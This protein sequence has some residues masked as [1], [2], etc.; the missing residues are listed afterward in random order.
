MGV[1]ESFGIPGFLIVHNDIHRMDVKPWK[2]RYPDIKVIA[3]A[4]ARAKVARVARVDASD[5]DFGDPRVLFVTLA[6]T[7]EREAALMIRTENGTTL[8]LNDIIFNL[9]NRPGLT[10]RLFAK[11][12]MTGNEPRIPFPVRLREVKDKEALGKQLET[13][14]RLPALRRVIVSHGAIIGQE[15]GQDPAEV[16]AAI[17]K[18]LAA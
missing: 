2:D 4:G 1:L 6:G 12:G 18:R 13:W 9:P 14:A 11:I 16:L 7:G 15:A 3:P 5:V 17:A 8:V 10:G